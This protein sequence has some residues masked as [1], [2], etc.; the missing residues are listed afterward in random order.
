MGYSRDRL[1]MLVNEALWLNEHFVVRLREVEY[2]K[3][4]VEVGRS[5]ARQKV[6]VNLLL[7]ELWEYQPTPEAI[8]NPGL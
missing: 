3:L 4:K 2:C 5:L 6:L 7:L 8:Y 1:V